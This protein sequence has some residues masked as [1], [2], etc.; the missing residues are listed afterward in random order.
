VRDVTKPV[1][2]CGTAVGVL[3]TVIRATATDACVV[4]VALEN[5]VCN[6]VVN[7]S[8][9]PI[10]IADCPITINGDAI[11]ITG[12]L[13]EGELTI[14]Y[15]A[16]AVDASGN[17]AMIS[18]SEAYDPDKDGD[19]IVDAEDNC[20]LTA[21]GDQ[22][23]SDDDGIGNA[24]DNCPDTANEDQADVDGDGIGNVCSDRDKD[25]VLDAAD[26][27]PDNANT[28]QLDIDGDELGDACDDAPYEG[29]TAEGSGGCAGG[30]A[31]GGLLGGLMGLVGIFAAMRAR[32]R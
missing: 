7:G 24:C 22:G 12:R 5:V 11:E 14:T 8:S 32:R 2:L 25:G 29:L 18:C 16:R 21:N 6:R 19:G 13:T 4:T 31:A 23:D 28:N 3:P 17:F 30:G 26:N 27:C 10:A 15:D 20:V 9:T 1:V